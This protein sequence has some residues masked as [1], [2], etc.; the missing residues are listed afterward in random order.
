ML[1]TKGTLHYLAHPV[2]CR[3][4]ENFL[5]TSRMHAPVN[6]DDQ[7]N[8]RGFWALMATQFQGA[9]NDN[10]YQWVITFY[11]L[12]MFKIGSGGEEHLYLGRFTADTF[13]PAFAT[14][15][16]SV[17]FIIFPALFGAISDRYSK[18]RVAV[19]VKWWEVINMTL[20]GVAFYLGYTPF[21]WLMFFFLATHSALFGPAKYGI[22][23]EILPPARLSWGNGVIQMGTMIAIIMGTGLAGPLY[24][25]ISDRVYLASVVLVSLSF[26][27]LYAAYHITRPPAANPLQPIPKNPLSPWQG[28][29]KYFKVI[30]RDDILFY[31]VIGYT[32]FWFVGALARQN[33]VK[34]ATADLLISEDLMSYLLASVA[35]GIGIGAV[36][37]GYLSRG[38]VELG[39]VPAGALGLMVFSSLLA[40]PYSA[41]RATIIPA[42]KFVAVPLTG[43]ADGLLMQAARAAGGH[44]LVVLACFLF[45]GIFAGL[46]GVPLAAAIQRRAPKGMKGGVIASVNMLTWVGIALSSVVFLALNSLNFSAYHIFVFMGLSALGIGLVQC[47]RSPIVAIRLFWWCVDGTLVK[48]HVTG[49]SNIPEGT[50]GLLL[51]NHET[52]VD[53]MVIQAALDREIYFVIGKEALEA[54]WIR[55]FARSMYLIPV[56]SD[57]PEGLESAV[58]RIR[59][60]IAR[61]NLVCVNGGRRLK[62]EGLELPWH[63]NYT[64]LLPDAATPLIPVAMNRICE[65][66]YAFENMKIKWHFP[67]VFRFPVYVRCGAPI[68]TELSAVK[69]RE[70]VQRENVEG[71]YGRK[72]RDDVLQYGFIRV[73]RRY[74]W[75]LCFADVLSGSLNYFKTLVGT[76][77]LAR[78]LRAHLSD[79]E[80][81]GVL[82]PSTVGGAL[83]N[84]ALQ[85]MGRIPV[86][87]NYTASSEIIEDCARRCGITH[88]LTARAFLERVPVAP[89]GVPVYLDDIRKTVSAKDQVV[90]MLMALFVPRTLL[91]RLLGAAPKTENDVATVIFSSGSEGVPKGIVLT[92]RNIMTVIE[93][94]REMVPHDKH[95]GIVAFLPF[96][97]SFGYAVTLWTPLMEGLHSIFH[98]N[99]LEPKPIAQ[100]VQKY[101]GNIM[102]ATPTFLQGFVRRVEPEML[103]T[104]NCVVAGAEKLP[105]RLMNSFRERFGVEP[106]EGYGATECS[107]VIAVGLPDEESPGFYVEHNRRGTVGHAFPFQL[108]KVVDPDTGEELPTGEAGLLLVKGPNVMQGY[109]NDEERTRAV[110]REGWY[111]T[112]DIVTLDEDGFI[113]ITDRLARFSKVGGEMV[114][115]TRVEEVLHNL[116][117]L[118]EQ[119]LIVMGVPDEARGE[120]LVVLHTLE[121]D[122]VETLKE[123]LVDCELPNLWRP[124]GNSFYRI[125]AIPLLG[126]GKMDI[127][128]AKQIALGFQNG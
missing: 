39:L 72:Y 100:L 20:G 122:Q 17:P 63:R 83:A 103:Q 33:L 58:T 92:H 93:G 85:T 117:G 2:V 56:D 35:I 66:L 82:M 76:I 75:R 27:G 71:Y 45:L 47:I 65:I 69:M 38:K 87:L 60:I 67:G 108:L 57:S 107:P 94:M 96:F 88:T 14:F 80:M 46:Y 89:P 110:M 11:L 18:Q 3:G 62:R 86:N 97:H 123:R 111:V 126:T 128:Q 102:V 52:F 70:A 68:S 61:G 34:F 127:R 95:S 73:A 31:T 16:F 125:D 77:A 99:P 26:L 28:M 118:T 19:F 25:Y 7:F 6:Q 12:G 15:L 32:F 49:R 120:R 40:V 44:Y 104:L 54:R 29:M 119:S 36:A 81:V 8:K 84:T 113:T 30:W 98:P 37:A 59:E 42:V 22:L 9:F 50:G 79:A 1:G 106:M 55:R 114:P 109:L 43:G 64:L 124:R 90:A 116:L 74:L 53:T 101:R 24:L 10:L 78:K 112:G 21:I 48:L 41:Y 51:G 91:T 115:H 5:M 13:V 105:D 4:N 23:P 121:N